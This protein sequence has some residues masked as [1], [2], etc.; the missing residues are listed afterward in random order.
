MLTVMAEDLG[1]ALTVMADAPFSLSLPLY[2][3]VSLFSRFV[4]PFSVA[5]FFF[6]FKRLV[7]FYTKGS[8]TVF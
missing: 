6:F 5:I 7:S 1:G 4:S 2:F 3:S 8:Q